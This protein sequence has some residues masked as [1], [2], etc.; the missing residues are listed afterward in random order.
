MK[1]VKI[2][3]RSFA[4]TV[5]TMVVIGA[6][7]ADS[8]A[9]SAR[10]ELNVLTWCDHTDPNLLKPFEKQHNV[11][12]NLKEY[13]GTGVALAL[14]EQSQPGD[15]DVFV[16]D[17]IDVK[18][19]VKLG[20]LQPLNKGDFPWDDIFPEIRT[21]ELNSVGG[22]FYAVPE[23]FGYNTIAYNKKKVDPDDMRDAA[24]LWNPKYKGR[25]AVYDYY[26][27]VIEMVAIGIGIKPTELNSSHLPAIKEKLFEIKE[28]SALVGDV[29][30]VQ[31]ALA[32]GEVDMIAGGGEF[33]VSVLHKENP[34]LD[35]VL[36]NQ[37]GVRWQQA[38]A[39]FADSKKK[40][41]A[42]KFIQYI[43]SPVGQGRLATS[44]CY[45]AMPANSKA[46][47]TP[48]QKMILRWDEQPKFLANS[49]FYLQPDESFDKAMLDVW[50][51]FLQK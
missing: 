19:V 44:S 26:I 35:W 9:L 14:L 32:T 50:T 13:D 6:I 20:L 30:Q 36:P 1:K 28:L 21:P 41:L 27:P 3:P 31:T 16:V 49:Y 4:L 46:V 11:R 48:E 18:R 12:V 43:L 38:I 42:I 40:D 29:V 17:S 8:P 10:N 51:E 37:G 47:L 25:I 39:V 7:W 23:K 22:K 5:L 45:W 2:M 34:D 24:V 15:W 33:A